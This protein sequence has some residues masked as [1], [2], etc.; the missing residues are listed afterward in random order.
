M[1]RSPSTWGYEKHDPKGQGAGSGNVRN[2]SRPKTV[3]TDIQPAID[4]REGANGGMVRRP[5]DCCLSGAADVGPGTRSIPAA[6]VRAAV[7]HRLRPIWDNTSSLI[8]P[9]LLTIP[10]TRYR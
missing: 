5:R 2:G 7:I 9:N 1:R 6:Q 4:I 3:L 10:T 8:V